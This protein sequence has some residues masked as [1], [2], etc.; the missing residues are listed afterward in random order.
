MR[1]LTSTDLRELC[2]PCA[3]SKE[4]TQSPQRKRG[5]AAENVADSTQKG[6]EMPLLFRVHLRAI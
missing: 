5:F 2:Y 4:K 1:E 3:E 6:W